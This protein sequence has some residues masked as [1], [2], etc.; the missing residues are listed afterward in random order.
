VA[1][2]AAVALFLMMLGGYHSSGWVATS[3]IGFA[4]TAWIVRGVNPL[5]SSAEIRK[6]TLKR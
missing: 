3:V 1:T 2:V 6:K 4:L 5:S